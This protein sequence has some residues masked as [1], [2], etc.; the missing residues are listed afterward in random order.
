LQNYIK[1][2]INFT[3]KRKKFMLT[4]YCV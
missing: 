2:F 4:Y 3:L 1:K